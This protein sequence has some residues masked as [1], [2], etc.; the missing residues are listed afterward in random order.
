MRD[1]EH[2]TRINGQN[3]RKLRF[4]VEGFSFGSRVYGKEPMC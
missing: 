3:T 4:R 2:Y 1:V